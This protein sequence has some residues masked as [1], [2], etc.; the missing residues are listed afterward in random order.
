MIKDVLYNYEFC[1]FWLIL[2]K[3]FLIEDNERVNFLFIVE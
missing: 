1:L 2:G 3:F